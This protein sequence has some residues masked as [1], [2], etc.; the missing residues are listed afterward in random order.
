MSAVM[1]ATLHRLRLD[2]RGA[3]VLELGL[4][5]PV[6]M[7]VVLGLID[8]ASCYS[9]QMS[10]QQATAR[11]LERVQVGNSRSDFTFVRSEAANAAKVPL[12]QVEVRTWLECNQVRQSAT[13]QDCAAGQPRA[14]YVQVEITAG[15]Q[16]YFR[17]SPLGAREANGNVR[18]VANSA[19]RYQ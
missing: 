3:G 1:R 2:R 11:A 7:V 12:S 16:P 10:L 9:A 5:L 19:V 4:V 8:V 6:L 15:Y 18:L 13:A 14:R 17:Y